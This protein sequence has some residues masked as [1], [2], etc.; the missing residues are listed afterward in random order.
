MTDHCEWCKQTLLVV[1]LCL[2]AYDLVYVPFHRTL[3]IPALC[4]PLTCLRMKVISEGIALTISIVYLKTHTFISITTAK[5]FL[6][7]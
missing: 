2:G 1:P 4:K 6:S 5:Q 3:H 7:A